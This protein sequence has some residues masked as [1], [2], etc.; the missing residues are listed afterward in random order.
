MTKFTH[1]II[2]FHS[3]NS[4]INIYFLKERINSLNTNIR[5]LHANR[6]QMNRTTILSEY[7]KVLYT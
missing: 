2:F 7:K 3:F 6:L 1:F 5:S 4:I